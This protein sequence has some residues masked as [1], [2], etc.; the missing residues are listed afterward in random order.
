MISLA[1]D[2]LLDTIRPLRWFADKQA[3]S[4][5]FLCLD[6]A[7]I[8]TQASWQ[9]LWVL[10]QHRPSERRYSFLVQRDPAGERYTDA[11][12]GDELFDLLSKNPGG[13]VRT[14]A[15]GYL[16]FN[17]S[18]NIAD[19]RNLAPLEKDKTTNTLLRFSTEKGDWAAKFYRTLSLN[20]EHEVSVLK[21]L[22]NADAAYT[23][24]GTIEY[25]PPIETG[26]PAS[27]LAVINKFIS[28]VPAY[29]LYSRSI[30]HLLQ[31]IREGQLPSPEGFDR[32]EDLHQL[33][34]SI[35][36][37]TGIFHHQLQT[38]YV[39]DA[40]PLFDVKSY[41]L[42]NRNRW[43]RVYDAIAADEQLD[44]AERHLLGG[45]LKQGREHF[46]SDAFVAEHHAIPAS[47]FHGDLHLSHIFV[48]AEDF[49]QCS[50]I[51]PSPRSLDVN[52]KEFTTQSALQDLMNLHRGMDYFSYDEILD[53]LAITMNI[54]QLQAAQMLWTTPERIAQEYPHHYH[55][56][57]HWSDC[58]FD[59]LLAGYVAQQMK[60]DQL[61]KSVMQLFYFCRLL[62]ELEY[63]YGYD[64][65]FFKYCDYFYL[66]KFIGT[67]D[68]DDGIS[69]PSIEPT[70][71]TLEE[72]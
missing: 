7:V 8:D 14:Q 32:F 59:G 6:C 4:E 67:L 39:G 21:V 71:T 10:L 47:I 64:R 55:L 53:D 69:A 38:H 45:Y 57:G 70:L 51:D 48:E 41:V 29:K 34:F 28:G 27:T 49:S 33:S 20:N 1:M 16:V 19:Y 60:V 31:T 23:I 62:K 54:P 25:L 11:T 18:E 12:Y 5:E 40:R 22:A 50:L 26:E 43:Q 30:K 68:A 44:I 9:S 17:A 63:N 36:A 13:R 42:C 46:L 61:Q 15:S 66:R 52:E 72:A 65:T 35:G 3:T 37:Q 56:L 2:A 24:A 58:V